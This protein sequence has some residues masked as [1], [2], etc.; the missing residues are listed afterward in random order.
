MSFYLGV[1]ALKKK[2]ESL[3]YSLQDLLYNFIFFSFKV[4][5]S[6]SMNK[7]SHFQIRLIMSTIYVTLYVWNT[8]IKDF[9]MF[10][11][12][13]Q[14]EDKLK[15]QKEFIRTC[16]CEPNNTVLISYIHIQIST[17]KISSLLHSG[18]RPIRQEIYGQE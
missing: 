10:P 15:V 3:K 2:N 8:H 12:S 7:R 13:R 9:L 18:T 11:Y 17:L 14:T 16:F 6:L 4:V 1:A 5:L